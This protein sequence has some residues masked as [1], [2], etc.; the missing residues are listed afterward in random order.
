[1]RRGRAASWSL[2]SNTMVLLV[3]SDPEEHGVF[4]NCSATLPGV[5]AV[6]WLVSG[7]RETPWVDWAR[8]NKLVNQ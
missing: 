8:L 2:L 1:M 5:L 3:V 4:Q 6:S 7:C